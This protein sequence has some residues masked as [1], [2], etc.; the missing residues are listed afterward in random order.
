MMKTRVP[1]T[2]DLQNL[3]RD[4][5]EALGHDLCA[6]MYNT[7][8]IEDR[9][10]RGNGLDS[11]RQ[12]ETGGDID[13]W[14]FRRFNGRLGYKQVNDLKNAVTRAVAACKNNLG[15]SL[16]TFTVFGS[17]DLE[18]GH[19]KQKGEDARISE[20]REWCK[21]QY[22]VSAYYRGVTWIRSRLLKYP[23]LRPNMFEDLATALNS[24]KEE[25]LSAIGGEDIRTAFEELKKRSEGQLAVLVQEA[26]KHFE[27]GRERGR[28]ENWRLAVESL[29]DAE[30]LASAP[31]VDASLLAQ[32]QAVLTGLLSMVGRLGEAIETGRKAVAT[33]TLESDSPFLRL[34]Q[35]NLAIALADTQDYK[36]AR[37]L[38]LEVL[39]MYEDA[40]EPSEVVR[41]LTNLLHIDLSIKNWGGAITWAKR[42][43][44]NRRQLDQIVGGVTD[45][46][47]NALGNIAAF[48]FKFA[49][50][51]PQPV[52]TEELKRARDSF[53]NLANVSRIANIRRT[54]IIA[55]A[56]LADVLSLLGQWD[57]ADAAFESALKAGD[58]EGLAKISAD[59]LYNRALRLQEARR[60][61]EASKV[62]ADALNRYMVIGD[63]ASKI[64][65]ENLLADIHCSGVKSHQQ[66]PS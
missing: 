29:Q 26:K 55:E 54:T 2:N 58:E 61:G 38:L 14:Q 43:E 5:W 3:T 46:S 39:R 25:I 66:T 60:L 9:L 62:A 22:D 56:T 53:Q 16:R 59:L 15:V 31:G 21:T 37:S 27:R 52:Q 35:G 47:L 23:F 19:G 41:T 32:I 28:D 8:R 36:D 42:L 10:G 33:A 1:T 51:L 57:D 65:A 20:F 63:L 48:H 34:A 45:D 40:A 13:G 18:P 12:L 7:E 4:E 64:D 44:E 24:V 50:E 49:L 17:L 30:R 11:F 6:T